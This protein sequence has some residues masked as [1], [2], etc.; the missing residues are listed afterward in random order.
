MKILTQENQKSGETPSAEAPGGD[1]LT[2]WRDFESRGLAHA[3]ETVLPLWKQTAAYRSYSSWI[4]PGMLQTSG[5]T[6][7]ILQSL[8][9][10]R[11]LPGDTGAAEA[12]RAGRQAL[13]RESGRFFSF[14]IEESVL[15]T[16]ISDSGIMAAQLGHILTLMSHPAVSLA[17][18]P[19][20]VQR[21][22]IWPAEDFV[23]FGDS[24]VSVELTSGYLTV[25]DP[26][27]VE[28]YEKAF[29]RL[30]DLAVRDEQACALI[31]DA[32]RALS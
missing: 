24:Q 10:R 4:V 5:Y 21:D 23:I 31:T 6:R 13:L 16:V 7:A 25:A 28:D 8:A 22:A 17:V 20:S 14:V 2:E 9:G 27:H 29:G 19:M 15:L 32:I 26:R 12:A 18:I 11:D 1:T 3:Q 30:S